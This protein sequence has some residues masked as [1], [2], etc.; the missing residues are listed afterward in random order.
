[1]SLNRATPAAAAC[2]AVP[3]SVAPPGLVPIESVMLPLNDGTTLPELSCTSTR[4]AGVIAAPATVSL[5]CTVNTSDVAAPGST[6]N[7]CDVA[8]PRPVAAAVSV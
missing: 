5:G 7:D 3:P 6:S 1:M 4:I 8:P 2:V